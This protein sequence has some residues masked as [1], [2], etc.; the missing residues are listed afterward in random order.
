MNKLGSH[1]EET[2]KVLNQAFADPIVNPI[3]E[4]PSIWV[5]STHTFKRNIGGRTVGYYWTKGEFETALNKG[6]LD[7]LEECLYRYLI[8]EQ[9]FAGV[10]AT[11]KEVIWYEWQP[12]FNNS[13]VVS[14]LKSGKW[15]KIKCPKDHLNIIGFGIG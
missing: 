9:T 12:E 2:Q 11:Q 4:E 1:A 13:H 8:C 5:V 6:S 15:A 3:L 14:S 7:H 10:Y